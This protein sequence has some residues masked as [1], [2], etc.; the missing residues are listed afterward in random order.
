[1]THSDICGTPKSDTRASEAAASR[2]ETLEQERDWH[3]QSYQNA[4]RHIERIEAALNTA[5]SHVEALLVG[6]D[7]VV[8]RTDDG[9]LVF[10]KDAARRWLS[11]SPSEAPTEAK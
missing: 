8:G 1:M 2:I 9:S 5:R 6:P 7:S 10:A 3:W 4:L 11:D